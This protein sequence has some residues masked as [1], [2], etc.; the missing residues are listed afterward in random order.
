MTGLSWAR[1]AVASALLVG[2]LGVVLADDRAS[3]APQPANGTP[4]GLP[5]PSK[6]AKKP[7]HPG[8][9]LLCGTC[10]AVIAVERADPPDPA[11]GSTP[12]PAAAVAAPDSASLALARQLV[13]PGGTGDASDADLVA[14]QVAVLP[15]AT[16]QYAQK[17]GIHVIACRNS[18]TD[19][20]TS[21]KG[22]QP[23]GW[24]AGSTWDDVPGVSVG[25]QPIIAILG[26]D[27]P[28]GPHIPT[29][30]EGQ[31]SYDMVVHELG[32]AFDYEPATGNDRFSTR[33]DFLA[34]RETDATTLTDYESQAGVAGHEETWAEMF[35]RFYG[36]D[37]TFPAQSPD[38]SR[39]YTTF[40]QA[41]ATGQSPP[42]STVP[43]PVDLA[44]IT[45]ATPTPPAL[46]MT[47]ALTKAGPGH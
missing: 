28:A 30:G 43:M 2:T 20:D 24:P 7:K 1:A 46:G 27:T 35:A 45:S 17:L 32:H 22:V 14:Q 33:S 3:P 34:A 10:G 26:H 4:S 36:G 37:P 15:V 8:R 16:L 29:D 23:R 41:F 19:F 5:L 31:G 21:L 42:P 39:I 9:R 40:A 11:D 6:P 44:P 12:A 47:E 13:A 25:N 18:I 38:L